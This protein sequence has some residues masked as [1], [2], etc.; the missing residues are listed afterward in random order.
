MLYGGHPGMQYMGMPPMAYMPPQGFY[1]PVFYSQNTSNFASNEIKSP[2]DV[3]A[4]VYE[5]NEA[6]I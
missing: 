3:S 4:H 6:S 1:P 2:A 5:D